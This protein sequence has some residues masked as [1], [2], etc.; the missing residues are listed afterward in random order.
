MGE[1]HGLYEGS[2]GKH[3]VHLSINNCLHRQ[4]LRAISLLNGRVVSQ[5]NGM[6]RLIVGGSLHSFKFREFASQELLK[7]FV[8]LGGPPGQASDGAAMLVPP[9]HT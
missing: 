7:T 9:E 3:L 5:S 6:L 2:L 8:F 1:L 4:I